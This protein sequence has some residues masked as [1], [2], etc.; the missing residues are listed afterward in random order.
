LRYCF[1]ELTRVEKRSHFLVGKRIILNP[2]EEKS[3]H[4]LKVLK[5]EDSGI[6]V[7][8]AYCTS[9]ADKGSPSIRIFDCR[10]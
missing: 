2:K 6:D 4:S 10:F 9:W 7:E 5:W 1:Q 3:M 8:L